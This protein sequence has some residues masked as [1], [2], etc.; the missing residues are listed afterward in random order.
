MRV[1]E[2]TTKF[3]NFIMTPPKQHVFII[4]FSFVLF[5][6]CG[7]VLAQETWREKARERW[8]QR[9]ENKQ[10]KTGRVGKC[11]DGLCDVGGGEYARNC[12]NDCSDQEVYDYF[13]GK[14]IEDGWNKIAVHVNGVERKIL[15]QGPKVW[16]NGAIITLHGGG[17]TYAN[18]CSNIPGIGKP[19]EDFG[20]LAVAEGFAVFSL[21]SDLGLR[22]DKDAPT[23]GKRFD[24]SAKNNY[25]NVDLA[26]VKK[27]I[28]EIIPQIRPGN[29]ASDIFITGISTGGFMTILAAT[30]FDDLITAFAPVAAGDPY[31]VYLDCSQNP[32]K[33]EN[34]PGTVYDLETHKLIAKAGG[35]DAENYSNELEWPSTNRIAKPPFKQFHHQGDALVDISC[36]KKIQQQLVDHGYKD[37]GD[38][39]IKDSVEKKLWKHFWLKRYN[40]PLLEFFKKQKKSFS[41][42]P[43]SSNGGPGDYNFSLQHDGLKRTYTVHVPPSYDPNKKNPIVMYIH[44]GGGNK[45]SAY[46]DKLDHASDK[47]GFILAIPEATGII[48]RGKLKGSWNGGRWETGECCG[49]A[50]DVGF[51]SAMIDQLKNDFNVAENKIYATGISNGGLM[52]NRLGCEL[53]NKIAAI[54]T[55]APAAMMSQCNPGRPVPFMDIHG[56]GDTCNDYNTGEA[57]FP[58]CAS[59]DYSRM[60]SHE[61]VKNWKEINHCKDSFVQGYHKGAASCIV[62]NECDGRA[63]VEFCTV[64]GM[65]HA[66]PSGSQYL[67]ARMVGPVSYDI[68]MDQIWGFFERHPM[69]PEPSLAKGAPGAGDYDFSIQ[70]E[71][72][73]R[74]Y[75]LHVPPSY[76][77]NKK[78]PLVIAFHGGG[79]KADLVDKQMGGMNKKSDEEGYIAVY[80]NGHK[81]IDVPGRT[82][83]WNAG[84]IF[85]LDFIDT[86]VDDVDFVSAMIDKI[87]QNF[88]VDTKK[89]YATG[90]SNGAWMSYAVACR[91]AD[92]IAAIAPIA[93]GLVLQDCHP[94]KPVSI[95]HF[96]GTADPGWP[97]DGGG[98]CWTDSIRPA[99][100]ETLSRWRDLNHCPGPS[101]ITYQKGRATCETY[102]CMLDS[103]IT[104]CT[105]G[106]GG[107][108]VPGGYSFPLEQIIPW[109]DDCALGQSGRGV[110]EV[111]KD[112]SALD[113]MWEF[114]KDQT[115]SPAPS[116]AKGALGA[117][118]Y[119]FSLIHD[120]LKRIYKVHVPSSYTQGTPT[121]VIL[122]FHG[123]G[124]NA[125]K[126]VEYYDLNTKSDRE[127]FIV[128]YPE[129]YGIQTKGG[130]FGSWNAGTCCNPALKDNIDDVGFVKKMIEKLENDFNVDETRI[131]ATGMSNGAMMSYALACELSDKIAAI[132]PAGAVGMYHQCHP[133]RKVPVMHF[134]GTEDPCARYDGCAGD[135]CKSCMGRYLNKI[136]FR[137]KLDTMDSMSVP[138]LMEEWRKRNACSSETRVTYQHKNATCVTYQGCEEDVTLCSIEGMGHA[139]PGKTTYGLKACQTNPNGR[140]CNLWKE[141][142]G[143]L[144]DDINANDAMWEFFKNHPMSDFSMDIR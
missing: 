34:T 35:C 47:H 97:Y 5:S 116:S 43:S 22:T 11:G 77:K 40:R 137:T 30:H 123:G 86:D 92:K 74:A 82:Y 19:M 8:K 59:M 128:V 42:S 28:T 3:K 134:H 131:F 89:I 114:F 73:T 91:L 38:F 138:N 39:V 104:F 119:D 10:Q 125:E 55:V 36:Q 2:I 130:I 113:A 117:G 95:I 41:V 18:F 45:E 136:G 90:A 70:H 118:D 76:D 144:S 23:C 143:P 102:A 67:P 63:E 140:L 121:P 109:D 68:S 48:K 54:T 50:D 124:G 85:N 78:I 32:A 13:E 111:S 44:G 81:C 25:E 71:G 57:T 7:S 53:S 37:D 65:G 31:G 62:Y 101:E 83:C 105:I 112:I 46:L 60:P 49:N 9:I 139:W 98:S 14:C 66:W 120:G 127:G 58:F 93:G 27:V 115:L 108:T 29:S 21:D 79:G 135:A 64:E 103:E 107:H 141:T 1:K 129:G 96:H 88:S 61:I 12:P 122:A 4:F 100:S 132:A 142:V 99:I 6:A 110:G 80:P 84:T 56:T 52:T 24:F 75:K 126:A 69:P 51:I 33:R 87:T 94:S 15:W 72:L 20:P 106:G 16:Q 133:K 26:F 17:G